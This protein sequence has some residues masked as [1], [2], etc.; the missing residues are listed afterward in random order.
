MLARGGSAADAMVAANA[1][2]GVVYPHMGG[3]GGDSFWLIHDAGSGRTAVLNATGRAGRRASPDRYRAEVALPVRGPAAVITVPGALEGWVQAHRNFG[4]LPF[5]DC[6]APAISYAADG[7]PVSPGLA[8]WMEAARALLASWP[9]TARC[10]LRPD[11]SPYRVGETMRLPALAA[12]LAAVA[13]AGR[14]AFYEGVIARRIAADLTAHGGVL[15]EDDFAGHTST[16][17]E[18]VRAPY[19]GWNVLTT[20]P[21]SQGFATLAIL[22]LVEHFD[23]AALADDPVAYIDLLVRATRTAFADRDR[24]LTDPERADVPLARLLDPGRVAALAGQ[25]LDGAPLTVPPSPATGGDTTFSCAVDTYGNVAA[26]IQ[27]I[28]FEWGS[29]FV[30]GDTGVLLHNRGSFFSLDPAHA[31]RL[32]PGKRTAHTLSATLLLGPDG[33]PGLVLG[34]MGGEGQPQTQAALVTRIIDQGMPVQ[35]AVDAPRWLY[36]RTWG[37]EHRGLRLE[38]RFGDQVRDGLIA[39][40]HDGVTLV[41][42]FDDLMGHAQ[43]IG[44]TGERLDAACDPRSDGAALGF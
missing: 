20:P 26:V 40:G 2:L 22:G 15:D 27:S 7:F 38:G 43:A 10:Y 21:N 24:Y 12:T 35:A 16:W 42:G 1:V 4:R 9:G 23:V 11:G 37:E 8:R 32:E 17:T 44:I 19:R 33:R 6:L 31:N 13:E 5:A 14:A 25:L 18:P 29:G 36:G 39:R 30:A 3:P 28:Y 41:G 34:T